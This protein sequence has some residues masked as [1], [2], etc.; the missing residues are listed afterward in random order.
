MSDD[1]L[2]FRPEVADDFYP[3]EYEMPVVGKRSPLERHS[4]A[5]AEVQP[6]RDRNL[7]VDPA[8]YTSVAEAER[9]WQ[10][11]WPKVWLC[12]GRV[13]DVPK[14][15]SWFQFEFGL[16][17]VLI[18]RSGE[19]EISALLNVCQHRGNQL[20]TGDFGEVSQFICSYHSWR[21][22]LEGRNRHITDR[23]YF[24]PGALCGKLDMPR[25]R[26]ETWGGNV[27]I[28]FDENAI[29]LRD[30]LGEVIDL[31][32][33][34]ELDKMTIVQDVVVEL[35][36]NWKT[37]LD[38]FS[39]AYHVHITH[40]ELMLGI[41]DKK[42]QHD[43]YPHG[44]S[45][46][47]VPIGTPSARLGARDITEVQRYMLVEAGLDPA[48]FAGRP[49]AVRAAIQAVKR[50]PDNPWELDYSRLTDA[51]L[52]DSWT[53]NIFPNLQ[54]IAQ[55]EGFL[56]QRYLPDPHDPNRCRQHIMAVAP[57]MGPS[58]RPPAYLGVKE[59]QDLSARPARQHTRWDD[60]DL[61]DTIGLVLW[62]DVETTRR[63]QRGM[64]SRGFEAVRFSEQETRNLHQFAE[65][66]RYLNPEQL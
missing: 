56:M 43:F 53:M 58:V 63:C 19:D 31:L 27:F 7:T 37:V 39:E 50:R 26:C 61:L 6:H 24:K 57:R 46:Q 2:Q 12:A 64:Q 16:E 35:G 30:Y 59:Q 18:V 4:P 52:T 32:D 47:W 15:G 20:V 42:L 22:D 29:S 41:E 40:P 36:C 55:P 45:R 25:I 21:Y 1:S 13:S 49:E 28:N 51:Q 34:Y 62:Q 10:R 9:E 14:V 11:F 48:D 44:H 38:A 66:D 60:P 17:S 23:K 33:P 5:L 3:G 8:R 54:L 65:L